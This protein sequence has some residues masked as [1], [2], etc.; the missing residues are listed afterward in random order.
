MSL[1]KKLFGKGS[2]L[3]EPHPLIS[4]TD[5]HSHLIPGIDDGVQNIEESIRLIREF[6][7]QGYKKLITTPHIMSDFFKNTPEIIMNGLAQVRDEIHRQK[8]DIELEAAAEYYIDRNFLESIGKEPL[9]SFGKN[10]VLVETNTINYNDVIRT[11]FFE[12][13]LS[14]YQPVLAHPERYSYFFRNFDQYFRIRD[15]EVYFQI[16]LISLTDFYSPEVRQ[17]A[18]R[19][20]KEGLV[21]F[22]G[23]DA[24]EM[25]YMEALQKA[26]SSP[27]L[28]KLAHLNLLNEEL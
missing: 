23:S 15:M 3:H 25:R 26:H 9:L 24:H 16:N 14:G 11:A 10:Y 1:I 13:R 28:E 18:E 12:L 20:I 6:S 21:D 5:I 7:R 4:S 22:I 8:I 2:S 17:I 19:L 27:F